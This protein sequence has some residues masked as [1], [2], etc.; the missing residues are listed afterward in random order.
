MRGK[1]SPS[2]KNQRFLPPPSSEGGRVRAGQ[3]GRLVGWLVRSV[4]WSV[5][6]VGAGQSVRLGIKDVTGLKGGYYGFLRG[7][8]LSLL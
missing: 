6:S 8:L 7:V 5:G 1:V 4:G 3:F 2:D